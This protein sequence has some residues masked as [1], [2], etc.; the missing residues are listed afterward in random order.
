ME[1]GQEHCVTI[2]EKTGRR[3]LGATKMRCPGFSGLP[4][5]SKVL[6]GGRT[7]PFMLPI[8]RRG[9]RRSSFLEKFT[10]ALLRRKANDDLGVQ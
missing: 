8:M 4:E 6:L 2:A 1:V 7:S 3:R 9:L 5:Q 10:R